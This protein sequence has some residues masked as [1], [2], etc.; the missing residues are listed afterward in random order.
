M[1][2]VGTFSSCS[3]KNYSICTSFHTIPNFF[4]VLSFSFCWIGTES[5]AESVK[6]A[7]SGVTSRRDSPSRDWLHNK[8]GERSEGRSDARGAAESSLCG[9]GAT[10]ESI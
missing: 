8:N 9:N 4:C 1:V 6:G 3:V 5:Q 10:E 2:A 7:S